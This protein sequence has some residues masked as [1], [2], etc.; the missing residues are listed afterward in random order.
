MLPRA[1]R[2]AVCVLHTFVRVGDDNVAFSQD[3]GTAEQVATSAS[4]NQRWG[5]VLDETLRHPAAIERE[6]D[7]GIFPALL[8]VMGRY[9][10]NPNHLRLVV[11][12]CGGRIGKK[13]CQ[14]FDE[15]Y[16]DCRGHMG[17]MAMMM[18]GVLGATD[19][20][21]YKLAEYRGVA[22]ELTW[23][24]RQMKADALRQCVYLPEEDL[25]RFGVD[26]AELSQTQGSAAFDR[27]MKFQIE[28]VR[29][30]YE[31]SS[32]LESHLPAR[33][34]RTSVALLRL[35]RALLDE[36]A[37]DPRKMLGSNVRLGAWRRWRILT[38][39]RLGL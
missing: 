38:R 21:A 12:G 19:R 17:A 32:Q 23:L 34:R 29:S 8:H 36:L 9:E 6:R 31:M 22:F 18:V 37:R 30:Y 28:R 35:N 27:L 33:A 15:L 4:V 1:Q 7:A 3:S 13:R 10:V 26:A 25:A 11:Q 16:E 5:E 24:L 2:D 20:S 39:T 14:T